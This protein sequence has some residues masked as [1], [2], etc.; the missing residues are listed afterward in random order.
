LSFLVFTVSLLFIPAE[1]SILPVLVEKKALILANSLFMGTWMI[2]SVIGFG[3]GVPITLFYGIN[4]TYQFVSVF[5]LIAALL[6][7]LVKVAETPLVKQNSISHIYRDLSRGLRFVFKHRVVFYSLV[8]MGFGI[9]FLAVTSVLA[10]SFVEK[11]LKMPAARFGYLV[12]VAGFGMGAGIY[13]I[14]HLLKRLKK[15]QV[16]RLGFFII[17]AMLIILSKTVSISYAFFVVFL[18]GLGNAFIT[19]PIQTIIQERSP[20]NIHGRVFSVQNFVA[21]IAFTF[22]PVLAGFFA[23][24]YG[25]N[26]VF[27]FVGCVSLG[28]ILLIKKIEVK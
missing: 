26:F 19:A 2:A 3:L 28:L 10:L 22:P 27:M 23:D 24:L 20:K 7:L 4:T 1:L 12:T 17:G 14:G 15:P 8:L 13:L 16:I 5:Y 6:I 25:Y 18:L 11:T 21:S 9:A